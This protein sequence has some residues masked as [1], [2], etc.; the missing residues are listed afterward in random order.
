[1]SM[2]NATGAGGI[3]GESASV[4]GGGTLL[5]RDVPG[6]NYHM[7]VVTTH[8]ERRK[9]KISAVRYR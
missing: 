7:T 4:P 6:K 1:M 9:E 5:N 3:G 2:G 8:V